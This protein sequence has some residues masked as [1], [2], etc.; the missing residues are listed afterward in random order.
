MNIPEI[1]EKI[2]RE[3]LGE[4]A[5]LILVIITVALLSFGLGLLSVQKDTTS[6]YVKIVLP[7]G[8]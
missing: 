4:T 5:A 3:G 2:K 8:K 7:E 6:N 1:K